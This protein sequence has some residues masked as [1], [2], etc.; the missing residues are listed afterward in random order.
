MEKLLNPSGSKDYQRDDKEDRAAEY[1]LWH[2]TLSRSCIASDVDFIE[3]RKRGGKFIPVAITE[4]T[5]VDVGKEVTSGYLERIVYRYNERDI[6]GYITRYL[7]EKLE[8]PAYIILYRQG[9][10][11]FWVYSFTEE[12]WTNLSTLEMKQFIESL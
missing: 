7:S 4:I 10:T 2:R 5:R 12:R 3:W 8:V 6:Q 9:C 11:E 1:R